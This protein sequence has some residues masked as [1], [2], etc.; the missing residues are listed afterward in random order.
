M[1][2]LDLLVRSRVP[3]FARR[4]TDLCHYFQTFEYGSADSRQI[5]RSVKELKHLDIV[6]KR[7]ARLNSELYACTLIV[8]ASASNVYAGMVRMYMPAECSDDMIM[9]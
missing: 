1:I 6:C 8:G 9:S 5:L 7:W 3:L 2:F 4:A